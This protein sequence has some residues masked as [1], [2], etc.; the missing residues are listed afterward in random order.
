MKKRLL[1]L[2][3]IL[4]AFTPTIQAENLAKD[5]EGPGVIKPDAERMCWYCT[6][7]EYFGGNGIPYGKRCIDGYWSP[8]CLEF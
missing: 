4:F 3:L 7:Y 2:L 5:A 8:I 1:C 6:E